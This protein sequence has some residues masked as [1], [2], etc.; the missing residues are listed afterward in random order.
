MLSIHGLEQDVTLNSV[1]GTTDTFFRKLV[2]ETLESTAFFFFQIT[3]RT[4]QRTLSVASIVVPVGDT[5]TE[6]GGSDDG[7]DDP[8]DNA[9]SEVS[10]DV[11]CVLVKCLTFT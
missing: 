10:R 5:T 4:W 2:S 7:K 9:P 1:E 3:F 11:F 6:P 8:K